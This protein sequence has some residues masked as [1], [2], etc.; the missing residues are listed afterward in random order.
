MN[1]HFTEAEF[2]ASKMAQDLGINN[3]PP[4]DVR[5][6][7][8][9]TMAS[10]ERIR[11]HLKYPIQVHSGYRCDA[12]NRAVKGSEKSQHLKGEACDFTCPLFGK[13]I[14]VAL[15][16]S[17]HLKDLGIDQMILEGSWVHVS[18]SSIPRHMVL[19]FKDGQYHDGI[20]KA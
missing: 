10:M 16:L 3:T 18:F 20:L 14:D 19:T 7:L 11:D 13:P 17:G 2:I 5:Q 8:K 6:K 1:D 15:E 4:D 9:L 12:L